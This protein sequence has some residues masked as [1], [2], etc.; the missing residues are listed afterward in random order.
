[1]RLPEGISVEKSVVDGCV[2]YVVLKDKQEIGGVAVSGTPAGETRLDP[3]LK[4]SQ[5][6]NDVKLVALVQQQ[7]TDALLMHEASKPEHLSRDATPPDF[8]PEGTEV[9]ESKMIP[10]SRCNQVIA[11]LVFSWDSASEEEM[12][13][14]G[15]KFELEASVSDYPIWI[16]GAPDSDD[17]AIAKHLTLQISPVKENVYWEHPNEMNKRLIAL[18]DDHC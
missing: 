9:F 13:C 4:E 17:D 2:T 16:L 14:V 10:C 18:D 8:V 5:N 7:M 6:Q 3:Y 12:E 15:K 1:M 11:H